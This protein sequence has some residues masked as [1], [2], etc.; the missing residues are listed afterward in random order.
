MKRVLALIC[1]LTLSTV[2]GMM[3][4]RPFP[5]DLAPRAWFFGPFLSAAIAVMGWGAFRLLQPT[6]AR[7]SRELASA[8]MLT[9][10]TIWFL[11]VVL[12]GLW[13][14][15]IRDQNDELY[16]RLF[17][18]VVETTPNFRPEVAHYTLV[19]LG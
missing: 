14:A 2:V 18:N 4:P 7:C 12:I 3:L 8:Q 15:Q 13:F 19:Q 5:E 11:L 10:A 9:I 16:R 1:I 17:R 6:R